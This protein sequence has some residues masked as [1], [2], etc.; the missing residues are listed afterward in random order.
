VDGF[1]GK[2][3][4]STVLVGGLL[5]ISLKW[6]YD[7]WWKEKRVPFYFQTENWFSGEHR[8]IDKAGHLFT[9]YF[10]FH[11]L[12]NVMLWGGYSPLAA[13]WW[14]AGASA[15]FAITVELGD[16]VG[17]PGFDYQDLVF[18]SAG[19]A[20]AW[21]QTD[22]PFLRNFG[23]KWSYIPRNRNE[24]DMKF[25]KHYDVHTYWLT[26]NVNELLPSSLEPI[27][28][29]WLQVGVGYGVDENMTKR[30]FVIGLDFNLDVFSTSS[31][32]LLL[33]RNTLN[34]FHYPAP[35]VKFTEDRPP[36]YYFFHTN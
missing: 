7:T 1:A 25:T 6:S 5:A 34:M 23:L 20:Y 28:P 4:V 22:Y 24:A 19:I 21:L 31:E 9:S 3:V 17:G 27:W 32:D 12:R 14:G 36:K 15:F 13:R 2:K 33:V 30:E 8:G 18:N 10:Y 29:D 16:A 26:A 35:A 11:T